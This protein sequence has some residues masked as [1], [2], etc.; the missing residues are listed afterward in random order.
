M[1]ENGFAAVMT[2]LESIFGGPTSEN[3]R[4]AYWTL[5]RDAPDAEAM[6]RA[7]AYCRSDASKYGFPKPAVLLGAQSTEDAAL[8]Q[9]CAWAEVLGAIREIGGYESPAFVDRASNQA[10]LTMGGWNALCETEREDL[11]WKEQE[12]R[13]LHRVYQHVPT[14]QLPA[15]VPGLHEDGNLLRGHHATPGGTALPRPPIRVE[16]LSAGEARRVLAALPSEI[17]A[18]DV[19]H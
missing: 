6:A 19:E 15:Y 1:T 4:R 14:A 11:H 3:T 7:E 18:P 17:H 8:R 5:L 16:M 13:R 2:L 9:D 12:F 10:I